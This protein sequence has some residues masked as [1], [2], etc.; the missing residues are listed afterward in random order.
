MS[1]TVW[2][3]KTDFDAWRSGEAFKEA[4]GGTSLGAFVKAMVSSLQ[5]LR[6]PPS[7]VFYDALLPVKASDIRGAGGD[8]GDGG[9]A[10][11]DLATKDG[12][13]V[14]E[15]DGHSEL[16][17]ECFVAYNRF[18]VATDACSAFEQRWAQRETKLRSADG[19]VAFSL[20]TLTPTHPQ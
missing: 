14:V 3:E 15:A 6:G 1:L 10:F 5:V 11:G 13:R 19:F 18:A 4:H 17:A 16:P 7:P 12:W 9:V 20:V 2:N 8:D